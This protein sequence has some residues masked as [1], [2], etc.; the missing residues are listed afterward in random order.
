MLLQHTEDGISTLP[1]AAK[2]EQPGTLAGAAIAVASTAHLMSCAVWWA[3][4]LRCH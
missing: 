1:P 2:E 3:L 4:G